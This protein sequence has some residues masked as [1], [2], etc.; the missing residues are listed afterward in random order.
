[1]RSPPKRFRWDFPVSRNSAASSKSAN[2]TSIRTPA[3]RCGRCAAMRPSTSSRWM[4]SS[5]ATRRYPTNAG[6]NLR[7]RRTG[8]ALSAAVP[9]IS[10]LPRRCGIPAHGA[11]QTHRQSRRGISRSVPSPA[12][13]TARAGFRDQSG[14]MLFDHRS[15]RRLRQSAGAMAGRHAVRAIW[16]SPAGAARLRPMQRRSCKACARR[17]ADVRVVRADIGSREDVAR[18]IAGDSFG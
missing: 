4:R 16:C 7:T 12:R 8:R 15:V 10:R 17:G 18:L 1:M 5:R 14:W 13:R 9:F 2:A 11:G 3:S 6:G